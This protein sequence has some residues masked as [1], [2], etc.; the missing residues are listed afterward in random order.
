MIQNASDTH[1]SAVITLN[2]EIYKV[3]ERVLHAGGGRTGTMVHMKL[4]NI[5]TGAVL[6][7]RFDPLEKI[8]VLPVERVRMQYLYHQGEI[9]TFMNPQTYEQVE[10]N[11]KTIGPFASYLTENAE[12]ELEFCE[13]KPLSLIH[14]NTV[15]L[16]VTTTGPGLKGKNDS[17]YK[18]ASLENG[19]QV[20]V[21][22]FIEE[23]DRIKVQVENGKYVARIK[24]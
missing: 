21:P 22:Q 24:N 17:T 11:G 3:I 4:R 6:E 9:Y 8:D 10:V 15:E 23:G 1:D 13:G 18:D 12:F 20:L 2:K 7:R 16:T 19:M 5:S 14:S